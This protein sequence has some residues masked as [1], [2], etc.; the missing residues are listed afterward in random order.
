MVRYQIHTA[1]KRN[2]GLGNVNGCIIKDPETNATQINKTR[3]RDNVQLILNG[4]SLTEPYKICPQIIDK[5]LKIP[6]IINAGF[7]CFEPGAQTD[8]HRGY[9][10]KILRC[11]IPLIIPSGDTA[12]KVGFKQLNFNDIAL[13]SGYFIFNDS[14]LHQSWN[15]TDK[16]RIILIIDLKK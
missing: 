3:I 6:N 9:N 2:K 11:H 7:S 5:L 13:S 16:K 12:I 15:N 1:G 8:L 4:K 10:N 14:C